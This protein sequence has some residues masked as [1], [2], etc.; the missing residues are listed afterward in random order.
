M[1]PLA[2]PTTLFLS[3]RAANSSTSWPG[4]TSF[5][6]WILY[7]AVVTSFSHFTLILVL[8]VQMLQ[9]DN[10]AWCQVPG[11]KGTGYWQD[12]PVSF[13]GFDSVT[14]LA[15]LGEM[16]GKLYVS[17][18]SSSHILTLTHIFPALPNPTTDM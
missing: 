14:Q 16:Q 10:Y 2:P 18:P 17:H 15:N 11:S 8:G 7:F 4:I 12:L 3:L 9:M 1:P 5:G 13:V 6:I